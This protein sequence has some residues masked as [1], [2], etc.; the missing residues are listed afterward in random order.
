MAITYEEALASVL[1]F[2]RT[3]DVREVPLPD[4]V[5]EV[6]ARD[7]IADRNIPPFPRAAM[8][9]F[10]VIWTG[11]ETERP[12]RVA[13]SVNPGTVWGGDPAETDCVRIMTGAKVPASFDTVIQIEHA[14]VDREGTVRFHTPTRRGQNIAQEGEDILQGAVLIP[15]GT[16]LSAH[17]VATLSSVGRWEVPVYRRPTVAVLSTGDELVE[18]WEGAEG[19]MI[20]NSNAHFLLAALNGLGFRKV[21][22][23]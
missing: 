2:V 14:E 6:L 9:G 16:Y 1:P 10:A 5:G 12:Y 15:S 23:L 3:R 8:D 17:H 20:R 13:G 19:P 22:Y 7:V 21:R 11:R 4:A 18:P